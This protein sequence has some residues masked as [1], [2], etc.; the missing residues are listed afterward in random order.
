MALSVIESIHNLCFPLFKQTYPYFVYD[1][2]PPIYVAH[3][4]SS[5][6]IF[7]FRHCRFLPVY[8]GIFLL[9]SVAPRFF[10]GAGTEIVFCNSYLIIFLLEIKYTVLFRLDVLL[11][12]LFNMRGGHRVV[13]ISTHSTR[14]L[15]PQHRREYLFPR[16][17][18]GIHHRQ[19]ALLEEDRAALLLYDH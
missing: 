13:G 12:M 7:S 16:H 18:R 1:S 2:V 6:M 14:Y 5:K 11:A 9:S 10:S 19:V 8:V 17:R 15:F 4:Q 3:S